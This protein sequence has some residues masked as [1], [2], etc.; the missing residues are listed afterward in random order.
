MPDDPLLRKPT[1]YKEVIG[2]DESDDGKYRKE[3]QKKVNKM[4]KDYLNFAQPKKNDKYNSSTMELFERIMSRNVF[5]KYKQ[6]CV[7]GFLGPECVDPIE[8]G[9]F[10]D[11]ESRDAPVK[12]DM[13]GSVFIY[14]ISGILKAGR[15]LA[16]QKVLYVKEHPLRC[17]DD[18]SS[19][20]NEFAA[21]K[22]NLENFESKF[23]YMKIGDGEHCSVFAKEVLCACGGDI[24]KK[25]LCQR[26]QKCTY[27]KNSKGECVSTVS[28]FHFPVG[29]TSY[30]SEKKLV[31]RESISLF[32]DIKKTDEIFCLYD[33]DPKRIIFNKENTDYF[34]P[35]HKA[36]KN[37]KI[38][39]LDPQLIYAERLLQKFSP[40][41]TKKA[42]PAQS[43]ET[44]KV[45][46]KSALKTKKTRRLLF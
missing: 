15:C 44:V 16:G 7:E 43:K 6:F 29:V 26:G 14:S 28:A 5:C 39:F 45:G 40:A 30:C 25:A 11:K 42:E 17:V 4:V 35:D 34:K 31:S 24:G 23:K 20:P 27:D 21:T 18:K 32:S 36:L 2:W 3:L 41:P 19:V 37:Q 38:I 13:L 9:A 46:R 8:R 12:K 1:H 22:K 33:F 10:T